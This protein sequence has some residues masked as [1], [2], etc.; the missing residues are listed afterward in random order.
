MGD[1]GDSDGVCAASPPHS[2]PRSLATPSWLRL[3][4]TEV[5]VVSACS[6]VE[7]A[8]AVEEEVVGAA[9]SE[10]TVLSKMVFSETMGFSSPLLS[11]DKILRALTALS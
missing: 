1:A 3:F 6:W 10:G 5:I 7:G 4:S 9:V 2:E 11:W 8:L